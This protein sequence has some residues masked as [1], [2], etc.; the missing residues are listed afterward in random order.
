M[1]RVYC[2]LRIIYDTISFFL[3]SYTSHDVTRFV[4]PFLFIV[5]ITILLTLTFKWPSPFVLHS[6]TQLN[7]SFLL[8]IVWTNLC[9]IWASGMKYLDL[10]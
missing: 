3:V 10:W 1:F 7:R 2:V 8:V 6:A 5:A 4:L 9:S